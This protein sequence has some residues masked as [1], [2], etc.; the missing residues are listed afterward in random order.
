MDV[1]QLYKDLLVEGPVDRFNRLVVRYFGSWN[2]L[3]RRPQVVETRGSLTVAS[4]TLPLR[5]PKQPKRG[6]KLLSSDNDWLLLSVSADRAKNV[7]Q[8]QFSCVL[9]G[10]SLVEYKAQVEAD[11]R[12]ASEYK[13]VVSAFKSDLIK[14][15]RRQDFKNTPLFSFMTQLSRIA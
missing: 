7:V 15:L 4:T 14:V 12:I 3:S 10:A 9:F 1:Q 6:L 11:L 5:S 2:K 8:C 13:Q